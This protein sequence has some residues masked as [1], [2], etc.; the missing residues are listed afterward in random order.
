MMLSVSPYS[1]G[2]YNRVGGGE[3]INPLMPL[4][5]VGL[6]LKCSDCNLKIIKKLEA[7]PY[8]CNFASTLLIVYS[9]P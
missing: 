6:T 4:K 3:I 9:R 5:A 8:G 7:K 2:P 1:C